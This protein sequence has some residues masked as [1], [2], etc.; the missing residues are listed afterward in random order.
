M[1]AGVRR[2]CGANL[3]SALAEYLKTGALDEKDCHDFKTPNQLRS[4]LRRLDESGVVTTTVVDWLCEVRDEE[5][6]TTDAA[7]D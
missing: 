2:P 3:C 7:A 4:M 5:G 6:T 1:I